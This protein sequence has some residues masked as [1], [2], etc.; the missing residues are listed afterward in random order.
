L[1]EESVAVQVTVVVPSGN[2]SGASFG[3][4]TITV[5]LTFVM[6]MVPYF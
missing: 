2:V 4:K 6:V 3:M 5:T 1:P